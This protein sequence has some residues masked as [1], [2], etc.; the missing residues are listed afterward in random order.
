MLIF[1]IQDPV[2]FNGRTAQT[3]IV[4][5]V[6]QRRRESCVRS[7]TTCSG[8]RLMFNVSGDLNG[9]H[10]LPGR[11]DARC[12]T[13]GLVVLGLGWLLLRPRDWRTLMLLGWAPCH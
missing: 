12:A 13:G 7:G 8:M 3:L 5:L 1:A 11:A 10:N 9:R 6:G 4:D 2:T